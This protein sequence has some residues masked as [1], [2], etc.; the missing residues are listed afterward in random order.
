MKFPPLMKNQT[1]GHPVTTPYSSAWVALGKLMKRPWFIRTWLVQEVALT[2]APEIMCGGQ[3]MSRLKGS[4]VVRGISRYEIRHFTT[5]GTVVEDCS[6]G[7][8][9]RLS[10]NMMRAIKIAMRIFYSLIA[11]EISLFS[12][13]N[14]SSK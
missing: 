6:G 8:S 4:S 14:R 10:I 7:N 3:C 9:V 1:R 13:N 5:P 12:P 11:S 2:A